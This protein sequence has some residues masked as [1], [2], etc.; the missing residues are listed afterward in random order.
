MITSQPPEQ[1]CSQFFFKF[2]SAIYFCEW[3]TH[4]VER[5]HFNL[6]RSQ[7]ELFEGMACCDSVRMKEQMFKKKR[8]LKNMNRGRIVEDKNLDFL[9]ELIFPPLQLR[10]AVCCVGTQ[11]RIWNAPLKLK[12]PAKSDTFTW[13]NCVVAHMYDYVCMSAAGDT[14]FR[15]V[16]GKISTDLGHQCV[17]T[18]KQ[19]FI[20]F[21]QQ[22]CSVC[23][24][25]D[26]IRI[27]LLLIQASL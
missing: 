6:I 12:L 27:L 16:W 17:Q 20:V 1:F 2:T 23:L 13:H 26:T 19:T 25:S 22:P 4:I 24:D 21:K 8:F 10:K 7:Q 15:A 3:N 11:N 9:H 18:F 5:E 14:G